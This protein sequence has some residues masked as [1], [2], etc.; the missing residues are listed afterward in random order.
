MCKCMTCPGE[1]MWISSH[2]APIGFNQIV[3]AVDSTD[4]QVP[5]TLHVT[6]PSTDSRSEIA[7]STCGSGNPGPSEQL[8][9]RNSANRFDQPKLLDD[10]SSVDLCYPRYYPYSWW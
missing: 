6:S 2:L 7:T 10:L 4:C 1:P 8:W 9:E 3:P 5:T